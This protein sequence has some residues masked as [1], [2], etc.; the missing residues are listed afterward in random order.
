M[1]N[2]LSVDTLSVEVPP[3]YAGEPACIASFLSPKKKVISLS[4]SLGA[5][6][7]KYR[8]VLRTAKVYQTGVEA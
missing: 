1:T 4:N 8:C 2:G 3:N 5:E 7:E 6:Q